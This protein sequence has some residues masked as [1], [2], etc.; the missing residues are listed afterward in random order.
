MEIT[1][2]STPTCTRCGP[3]IQHLKAAGH[4]VKEATWDTAEMTECLCNVG[5]HFLAVP[6]MLVDGQ[7]YGPDELFTN[8][9]I[10][11]TKKLEEILE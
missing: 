5:K 2:F 6:V 3:L 8:S 11:N 4:V 10:I 9:T 7:Y 1:I